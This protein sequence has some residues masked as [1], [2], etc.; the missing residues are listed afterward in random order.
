M[1]LPES[2]P[3]VYLLC[4]PAGSGK[5]T[6]AA[7]LVAAGA[8]R[9]SIDEDMAQFG[10]PYLD[11]DPTRQYFEFEQQVLA[12]HRDRMLGLIAAGTTVVLDYG[13][14]SKKQRTEYKDLITEQGGNWRL[15]Y[16]DVP[17]EEL[18]RRVQNRNAR[19]DA[20]AQPL[21]VDTHVMLVD[22]FE[23]PID[24]GE[25]V[26]AVLSTTGEPAV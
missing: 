14:P 13:F 23:V 25:E 11:Y 21:D 19:D 5:T 10:E 1:A 8:V 6:Y 12:E 3:D 15:L 24:E 4:G 17:I 9:L 22:N 16:F 20:N 18:M 2:A 7:Q 26:I